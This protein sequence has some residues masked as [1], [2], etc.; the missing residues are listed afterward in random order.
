MRLK[1][2]TIS[3]FRGFRDKQTLKMENDVILIRGLNGTGKSSFVEALEWLFFDE[4]SRKKKSLCKSEYIGDFLRNLHCKEAQEAF[5]EVLADISG[6]ETKLKKKW[7]SPQKSEYY[8]DDSPVDDFSSIGIS[9]AEAFK[10]ILAQVEIKHYVE[11]D[12]KDRW[13]ET[14]RILGLGI[15]S[16]FRTSLQELLKSKKRESQYETPRKILYGLETELKKFSELQNLNKAI[17]HRPF[18]MKRLE[19]ELVKHIVSIY[20]FKAKPI[21]ELSQSIDQEILKLAQR[22]EKL[23]N[24]QTLVVPDHAMI[25]YPLKLAEDIARIF[26]FLKKLRIANVDLNKFLE[27]GKR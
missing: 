25:A 6:K 23:G 14:N 24:I 5:V 1:E 22:D 9:F 19:K 7:V 21:D 2:V 4:I 12:P 15:L 20:S 27:I 16:E 13:E 18:S 3:G 11:T 8:I 10:P 17:A 26:D